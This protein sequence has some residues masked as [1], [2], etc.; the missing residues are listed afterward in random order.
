MSD[1]ID[2]SAER[3]RKLSGVNDMTDRKQAL[4]YL[5]GKVEAADGQLVFPDFRDA[6]EVLPPLFQSN[7]NAA[8]AW[9]AY[10]GSLDAA[11]ALHEVVLPYGYVSFETFSLDG[12]VV[13]RR[14][15]P[16]DCFCGF[17]DCDPARA[18]LIT[19]LKAL[20]AEEDA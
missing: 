3:V 8:N 9:S 20:I 5:L 6:L 10:T 15:K 1:E 2:T 17:A 14:T 19:I 11:K 16:V 12:E 7:H 18:W 13:L 4:T